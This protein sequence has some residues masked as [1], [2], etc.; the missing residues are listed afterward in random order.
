METRNQYLTKDL[1]L[2][3]R[4]RF[5][6]LTFNDSYTKLETDMIAVYDK[7]VLGFE[8]RGSILEFT[9]KVDSTNWYNNFEINR[10]T[11]KITQVR[12]H[13]EDPKNIEIFIYECKSP[14][15]KF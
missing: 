9:T 6:E 13:S 8:D 11:G 5:F 3:L 2:N 14:R 15:M 1:G 7:T 12:V 4:S 10:Y